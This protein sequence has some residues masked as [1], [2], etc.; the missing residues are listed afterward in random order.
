MQ[1]SLLG[2]IDHDL[3]KSS[4]RFAPILAQFLEDSRPA[5]TGIDVASLASKETLI[6]IEATASL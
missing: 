3:R 4:Y 1:I 6:E 5:M 2:M